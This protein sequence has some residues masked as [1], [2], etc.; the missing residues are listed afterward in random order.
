MVDRHLNRVRDNGDAVADRDA[1]RVMD[2]VV[3]ADFGLLHPAADTDA[4][5]YGFPEV[6]HSPPESHLYSVRTH[7]YEAITDAPVDAALGPDVRLL[8]GDARRHANEH[9]DVHARIQSAARLRVR[10]ADVHAHEDDAD[11]DTRTDGD[12]W[13]RLPHLR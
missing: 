10:G 6:L 7:S 5:A 2:A 13:R 3:G 4:D 1:D 9:R 11:G 12:G 8:Y